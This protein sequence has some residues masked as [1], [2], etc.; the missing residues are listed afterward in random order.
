MKSDQ[1]KEEGLALFRRGRHD[2][3]LSK[4][5]AAAHAYAAE[6]DDIGRGEALNNV[7]VVQRV[8]QEWG[9]S[10]QALKEAIELFALAGED[11]RHGQALGNLGDFYAFRGEHDKAAGYYSD[12]AELLARSGDHER[13]ALV[14]RALSLLRLRQRRFI[15]AVV[16]MEQSLEVRPRLNP[17]KRIF[18]WL[19]HTTRR[20]MGG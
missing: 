14:L 12:G 1:L 16:L 5:E 8:R 7:G 2:E 13:Q 10:E 3:A 11:N 19:I 18:L 17:F 4:F 15:E 20:L 6:G 9:A